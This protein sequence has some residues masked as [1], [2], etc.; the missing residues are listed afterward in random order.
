MKQVSDSPWMVPAAVEALNT[1]ITAGMRILEFGVGGSTVW[2]AGRGVDLIAVDHNADWA[3]ATRAK[4]AE[5]GY[6]MPVFICKRRPYWE[7]LGLELARLNGLI[8]DGRDRVECIRANMGF[9][10][11]GGFVVLDNTE[12][13][14]YAEVGRLLTDWRRQDF[15]ATAGREIQTHP[16]RRWVTSIFHRRL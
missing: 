12:R 5:L 11:P 9:V 7:V 14:R 2:L 16:E 3:E 1:Q 13:A 6:P 4:I 10:A 15:E 8:V